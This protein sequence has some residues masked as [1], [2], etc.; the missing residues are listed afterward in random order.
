MSRFNNP[1][2][3]AVDPSG[4]MIY[5]ADTDNNMIRVAVLPGMPT[6]MPTPMPTLYYSIV[7]ISQVCKRTD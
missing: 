1:Y 6:A 3:V 7:L 2:G 5:I 4:K